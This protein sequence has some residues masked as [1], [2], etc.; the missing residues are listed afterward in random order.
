MKSLALPGKSQPYL[1]A[2]RGNSAACPENTLPAFRRALEEGADVLETDLHLT[3]DGLFVCIHDGTVDRTTN[4]SGAVAEMTLEAL[5]ALD[6]GYGRAGFSGVEIPTLAE[7]MAL[8]PPDCALALELK[9]DRFLEPEVGRALAEALKVGGVR[10]RTLLVSFN[11]PR[12]RAVQA[13]A[14]DLPIGHITLKRLRPT[15][16]VQFAG[17]F[18]PVLFLNPL[19]VRRAH[20]RGALVC[21]L[22]VAPFFRLGYYRLLRCDAVMANDTARLAKRLGKG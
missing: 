6:A 17:P 19:F 21:P 7:T 2:H 1:M 15:P 8:I 13:V 5:K 22:D 14:P 18:W 10:D 20:R 16:D 3:A 12:L 4:G 9:S 11:L